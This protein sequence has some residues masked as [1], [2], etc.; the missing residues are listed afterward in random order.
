MFYM[1]PAVSF[2]EKRIWI[3][4]VL[5]AVVSGVYFAMVLSEARSTD[6]SSIAYQTPLLAAVGVAIVLSIV[7]QIA[8]SIHSPAE[9]GKRDD[10]DTEISRHGDVVAFYVTS[11]GCAAAGLLAMARAEYFWIANTIYLAFACGAVVSSIVKILA[12]RRGL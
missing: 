7:A 8:V 9:A 3:Y 10:R 11:V 6:V 2:E 1:E 5:S 4:G 12:Y